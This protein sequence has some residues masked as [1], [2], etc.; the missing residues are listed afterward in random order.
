MKVT[1]ILVLYIAFAMVAFPLK[2]VKG[3]GKNSEQKPNILII[4]PDDLGWNDVG[5]NGSV[6]KIPPYRINCAEIIPYRSF[7]ELGFIS[8]S[9]ISDIEHGFRNAADG[10]LL[11]FYIF[12][13]AVC[14]LYFQSDE[15]N[16]WSCIL[17]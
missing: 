12:A 4:I 13:F 1:P 9:N 8:I 16:P 15:V 6:I 11:C 5:Y 3:Q 10:D 14:S 7:C 2:D 17:M